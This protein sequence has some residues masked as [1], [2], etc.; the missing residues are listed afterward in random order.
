LVP[1]EWRGKIS[2]NGV[3]E[4]YKKLAGM[5]KKNFFFRDKKFCAGFSDYFLKSNF[6]RISREI[7]KNTLRA[8]KL[9]VFFVKVG[10]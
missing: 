8:Y 3:I 1:K 7:I 6:I 5:K 2:E 4:E 9:I 10:F